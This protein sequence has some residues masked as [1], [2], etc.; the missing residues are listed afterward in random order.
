MNVLLPRSDLRSYEFGVA[1]PVTMLSLSGTSVKSR[2]Q[3]QPVLN[4]SPWPRFFTAET[5]SELYDSVPPFSFQVI[6]LKAGL[7][8]PLNLFVPAGAMPCL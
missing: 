8:Y 3:V 2:A 1:K 5:C 7:R 6:V 4:V